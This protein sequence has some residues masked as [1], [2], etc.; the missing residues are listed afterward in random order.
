[1]C[2]GAVDRQH[3]LFDGLEHALL[4]PT[5]QPS[6]LL[7]VAPFHQENATLELEHRDDRNRQRRRDLS[8]ANV[9]FPPFLLQSFLS[10]CRSLD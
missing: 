8:K 2:D 9:A 10:N 4:E 1:M 3:L 5:T 7:R 6:A